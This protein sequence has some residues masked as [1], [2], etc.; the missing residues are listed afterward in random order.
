MA[1]KWPATP[2]AVACFLKA[3]VRGGDRTRDVFSPIESL[4]RDRRKRQ[5]DDAS[6]DVTIADDADDGSCSAT[7]GFSR[8]QHDPAIELSGPVIL[9]QKAPARLRKRIEMTRLFGC[10]PSP[11][12]G[13]PDPQPR[14]LR[15]ISPERS[16]LARRLRN[17]R[18]PQPGSAACASPTRPMIPFPAPLSPYLRPSPSAGGDCS[19]RL[20]SV[21]TG[22]GP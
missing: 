15:R 9:R 16:R 19:A 10:P 13:S 21:G 8:M 5:R 2:V 4:G 20:L 18:R 22:Q 1:T 17:C 14:S 6:C 7:S 12:P 3:R 11:I